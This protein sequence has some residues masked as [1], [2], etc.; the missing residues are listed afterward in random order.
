MKCTG[1]HRIG[2]AWY[3]TDEVKRTMTN[4][5]D[6][7]TFENQAKKGLS[8][9][10]TFNNSTYILFGVS[11]TKGDARRRSNLVRERYDGC[12][13]RVVKVGSQGISPQTYIYAIYKRIAP[14]DLQ[15]SRKWKDAK[16]AKGSRR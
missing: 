6:A 10:R 9:F 3:N 14:C 8:K 12:S 2:I 15:E 1:H 7:K 16:A 5:I 4:H 13:V 11:A